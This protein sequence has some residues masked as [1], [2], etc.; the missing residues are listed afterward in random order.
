MNADLMI[1]HELNL[2]IDESESD[3]LEDRYYLLTLVL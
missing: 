1:I 3:K 2:L